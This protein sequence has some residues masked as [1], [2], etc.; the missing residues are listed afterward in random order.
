MENRVYNVPD[1][2]DREIARLKLEAMGVDI[3]VLTP[4]Q[5]EYLNAWEHGTS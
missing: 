5:D 4:E 1:Q 2:I 3:D